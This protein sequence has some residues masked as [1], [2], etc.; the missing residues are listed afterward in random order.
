MDSICRGLHLFVRSCRPDLVLRKSV[1]ATV[2]VHGDPVP[3][4]L[5]PGPLHALPSFSLFP[6]LSGLFCQFLLGIQTYS[7]DLNHR[8]IPNVNRTCL[9][10]TESSECDGEAVSVEPTVWRPV[11]PVPEPLPSGP[12]L[13]IPGI[14]RIHGLFHF[15]HHLASGQYLDSASAVHVIAP[16]TNES[17][18]LSITYSKLINLIPDQTDDNEQFRTGT[19]SS[20]G[21]AG[22]PHSFLYSRHLSRNLVANSGLE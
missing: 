3:E 10:R 13:A 16:V 14:P 2:G 9:S 18:P 8:T 1:V 19:S 21:R 15:A 4:S 11:D 22:A 20:G 17:H 12:F 6:G 5:Q 7:I